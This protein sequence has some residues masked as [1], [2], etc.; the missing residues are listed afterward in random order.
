MTQSRKSWTGEIDLTPVSG[1]KYLPRIVRELL[2][3]EHDGTGVRLEYREA[4]PLFPGGLWFDREPG[5]APME[6]SCLYVFPPPYHPVEVMMA[7]RGWVRG[8]TG[9]FDF[10]EFEKV[11]RFRRGSLELG[12]ETV[13]AVTGM[14]EPTCRVLYHLLTPI[15]VGKQQPDD[16]LMMSAREG[17]YEALG[18]SLHLADDARRN[19]GPLSIPDFWAKTGTWEL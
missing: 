19:A 6:A 9:E 3:T 7:N 17:L 8:Y 10:E 2:L 4:T 12:V 5:A 16:T 14:P 18:F 13:A 1:F 11:N 15:R